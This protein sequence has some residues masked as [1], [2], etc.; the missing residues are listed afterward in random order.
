MRPS[1]EAWLIK[2]PCR[3]PFDAKLRKGEILITGLIHDPHLVEIEEG[4]IIGEAA[5]ILPHAIST[6]PELMLTIDRVKIRRGA[7]V[8]AGAV[9]LPGVEVGENS[10]VAANAVVPAGTKIPPYQ[11]WGGVPA[12][13]IGD[14]SRQGQRAASGADRDIGHSSTAILK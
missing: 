7:I 3:N 6:A 4:V 13:N 1:N 2:S 5:L 10:T 9:L 14:I 8:G 11:I 12:K